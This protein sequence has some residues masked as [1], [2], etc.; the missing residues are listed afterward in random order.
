MIGI[1]MD[2]ET[3]DLVAAAIIRLIRY[4]QI[5]LHIEVAE[6]MKILSVLL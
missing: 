1:V 2:E 5:R 3:C 6:D 4:L